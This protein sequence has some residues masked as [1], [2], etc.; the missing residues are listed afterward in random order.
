MSTMASTCSII[1][2]HSRRRPGRWCRTTGCRRRPGPCHPARRSAG[3]GRR[4]ARPAVCLDRGCRRTSRRAS[5]QADDHVLDQLLRV[6][7]LAGGE[8]RAHR[9]ALAALH[10]GVEPEQ[11]VP[12]EVA[13][14]FHA[15]RR[16]RIGQVERLE[17]GGRPPPAFGAAVPGQVQG[18]GEGMLHRPAPGHA[19]EQL[20]HAPGHANGEE[21]GEEPAAEAFRQDAGHRRWRGRSSRRTPAGSSAGASRG[22]ST[23]AT[24]GRG[25]GGRR[26]ARRR[27]SA[28]WPPAGRSRGSGRAARNR[29]PGSPAA[30][31]GTK[32]P[33]VATWVLDM[34]LSRSTTWCRSTR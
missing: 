7:R 31:P 15:Q 25:G 22:P 17:A 1:I 3:A 19:E 11:L 28:P 14:F 2:G 29:A 21:A 20:G 24:V 27:T 4:R 5:G 23:A 6:Q 13:G 8:R 26:T 10:A 18:T 9:L 30:P 12:G 16:L 33:A 34:Y 32:P